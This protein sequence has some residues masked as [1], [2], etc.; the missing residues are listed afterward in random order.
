LSTYTFYCR[1]NEG[2]ATSSEAYELDSDLAAAVQATVMLEQ[3]MNA[4]SIE[5]YD[6]DRPVL[7]RT[8]SSRAA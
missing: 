6:H 3:H 7:T 2:P 5:V 1:T 8:R 4:A